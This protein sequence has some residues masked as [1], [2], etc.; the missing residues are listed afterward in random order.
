MNISNQR[1][2][3]KHNLQFFSFEKY[4]PDFNDHPRKGKYSNELS[5]SNLYFRCVPIKLGK[6]VIFFCAF[7]IFL[8]NCLVQFVYSCGNSAVTKQCIISG[9]KNRKRNREKH[10]HASLHS[11]SYYF[12]PV[13][14]APCSS[15]SSVPLLCSLSLASGSGGGGGSKENCFCYCC[16]IRN[17]HAAVSRVKQQQENQVKSQRKDHGTKTKM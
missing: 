12:P 4:L 10:M 2:L 5:N 6:L 3:N 7:K 9:L 16:N 17:T 11:H 15:H 8:K 14:S 1:S 13:F